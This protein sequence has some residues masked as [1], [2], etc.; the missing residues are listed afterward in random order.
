MYPTYNAG[1]SVVA[2]RFIKTLKNKIFRHMTPVSRNIYFDAW[3]GIVDNYNN[4]FHRT[5]AMKLMHVKSDSNAECNNDSNEKNLKF[6]VND[7][8]RMSKYKNILAKE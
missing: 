2:E 8:L 4:K 5:I 6:K 3:D 1:N 7:H